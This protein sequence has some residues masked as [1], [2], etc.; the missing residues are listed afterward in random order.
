MSRLPL[1]FAALALSGCSLMPSN[2]GPPSQTRRPQRAEAPVSHSPQAGQCLNELGL[3]KAS[4]KPLPDKYYGS[5]C[6]NLNSVQ[7][8]AVYSDESAL[9]VV[10]IGPVTCPVANAFA[11][12]ARYGVDRAARKILGSPIARIETFGSYSCRN[13]A[14]TGRRSAH[15]T[16]QAID[17]SAFV[18]DD[19]RRIS[20]KQDWNSGSSAERKFLRIV[21]DSACKRF[22]TVLG[23]EYNAAHRDHFHIEKVIDGQ[24]YCR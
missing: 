14:G 16:A 12:W 21:H 2:S 13:V 15:A 22:A 7:L 5:G 17:I 18:L 23:P 9:G 1:A 4:F 11:G 19:G 6:S 20:V 24:S 8:S 3:T 10:N